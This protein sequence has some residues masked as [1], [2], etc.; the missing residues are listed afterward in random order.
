M[1]QLDPAIKYI[2]GLFL[3]ARGDR[4][5]RHFDAVADWSDRTIVGVDG[6]CLE[7]FAVQEEL[8]AVRSEFDARLPGQTIFNGL[9]VQAKGGHLSSDLISE[10]L[11]QARARTE[12]ALIVVFDF[13]EM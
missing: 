2:V 8:G 4:N 6:V 7:P 12:I 3:T 10:M 11:V 5:H 9:P 1:F 13:A